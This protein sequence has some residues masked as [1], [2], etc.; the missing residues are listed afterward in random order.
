MNECDG[1][2]EFGGAVSL[3]EQGEAAID[4]GDFATLSAVRDQLF[5]MYSRGEAVQSSVPLGDALEYL[6]LYD[7]WKHHQ[8]P[9]SENF[10][11]RYR[12]TVV[13]E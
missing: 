10:L 9:V 5:E 12:R 2:E 3:I 8:S 6:A 13:G 7:D 11:K 4:R 1:Y